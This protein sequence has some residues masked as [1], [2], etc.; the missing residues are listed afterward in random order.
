MLNPLLSQGC[1]LQRGTFECVPTRASRR[2][3]TCRYRA[4]FYEELLGSD[5]ENC[6]SRMIL[7]YSY[8]S[9]AAVLGLRCTDMIPG[10]ILVQQQWLHQECRRAGQQGSSNTC[11][12][13]LQ[14]CKLCA[15]CPLPVHIVSC[16]N[17]WCGLIWFVFVWPSSTSCFR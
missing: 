7:L 8:A 2:L 14:L 13:A 9:S 15:L 16:C 10:I 11:A 1:F 5:G 4:S 3:Y 12:G 17:I 6:C